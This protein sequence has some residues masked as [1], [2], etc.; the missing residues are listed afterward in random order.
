MAA[1]KAITIE[2][3][4]FNNLKDAFSGNTKHITVNINLLGQT[5]E[6]IKRRHIQASGNEDFGIAPLDIEVK[7]GD[8]HFTSYTTLQTV[9]AARQT[10]LNSREIT[11][12]FV[13]T[14]TINSGNQPDWILTGQSEQLVAGD[15]NSPLKIFINDQGIE[16]ELSSGITFRGDNQ[17]FT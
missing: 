6:S 11:I 10:D 17:H 14:P 7:I 4:D 13:L 2:S 1:P 3:A 5:L 16:Q 8:E 12:K 9:L 15:G